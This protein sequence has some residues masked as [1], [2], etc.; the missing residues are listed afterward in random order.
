M[1][2]TGDYVATN[3]RKHKRAARSSAEIRLCHQ[4]ELLCSAICNHCA[5][6]CLAALSALTLR[7]SQIVYSRASLF[8]MLLYN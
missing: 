4:K 3:T 8:A 1:V 2:C 5:G 7:P 6:T